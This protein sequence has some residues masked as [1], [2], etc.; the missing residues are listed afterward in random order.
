MP[1]GRGWSADHAVTELYSAHHQAL[2]RLAALLVQD[3]HLAEE[4]VQES[5]VAMHRGWPRLKDTDAALAYLRQAVVNR[6]RSVLRHRSAPRGE[7][8]SRVRRVAQ[9]LTAVSALDDEVAD[10]ILGDFELAL[11]VR[12]SGF[13]GPR[14]RDRRCGH[15]RRARGQPCR[16]RQARGIGRPGSAGQRLA[17]SSGSGG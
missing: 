13:P 10:Q 9:V 8:Q 17:G 12:R 7:H 6:S 5:F 16:D 1:A 4:V 3:V 15:L 11:A 14:E 2:L